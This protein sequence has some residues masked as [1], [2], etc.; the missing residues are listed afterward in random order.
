M[1]VPGLRVIIPSTP[2]DAKGLML[3]AI[4][5]GNPTVFIEHVRL[6]ASRGDV[7]EADE[8]IPLGRLRVARPGSDVTI[9]TYSGMLKPCLDAAAKLGDDGINCEVLDLRT[10]SP[11]DREGICASV[12]KT[13][14]LVVAHEAVKTAGVGAEIAQTAIE[15]AFDYLQ[16]PIERVASRDLP[17]PTGALQDVVYPHAADVEAAVR[18]VMQ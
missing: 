18:K 14:R 16:A 13:G 6:Y 7:P 4:R 9:V 11:L 17:I 10:L 5:D 1:H 3:A 8:P 2:A 15:G 12:R